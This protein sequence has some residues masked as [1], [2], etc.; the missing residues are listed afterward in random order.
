MKHISDYL[1]EGLREM[2]EER[3]AIMEYEGG[4]P[5]EKAEALAMAEAETYQRHKQSADQL[6][7]DCREE[8]KK[9]K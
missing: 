8:W 3:A 4:L 2:F 9:R 1:E 5:R 6:R 7:A